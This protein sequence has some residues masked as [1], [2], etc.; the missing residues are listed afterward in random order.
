MA[1]NGT[2]RATHMGMQK[3]KIDAG[4]QHRRLRILDNRPGIAVAKRGIGKLGQRRGGA[5]R[6]V[7]SSCGSIVRVI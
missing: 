1:L 3:V 4:V 2:S 6:G 5:S 7:E